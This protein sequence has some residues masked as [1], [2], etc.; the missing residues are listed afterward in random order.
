LHQAA[1]QLG[2]NLTNHLTFEFLTRLKLYFSTFYAGEEIDRRL[3]YD[4]LTYDLVM[5]VIK[6][7]DRW[8]PLFPLVQ[9][10]PQVPRVWTQRERDLIAEVRGWLQLQ[11]DEEWTSSFLSQSSAARRSRLSC[12][13]QVHYNILVRLEECNQWIND[14]ASKF[15]LFS[16]APIRSLTIAHLHVTFPNIA[17]ELARRYQ[18][19]FIPDFLAEVNEDGFE[20]DNDFWGHVLNFEPV[21][22]NLNRWAFQ[23]LCTD[24]YAVSLVF[25]PHGAAE[26][27][28][29]FMEG[30]PAQAQAPGQAPVIAEPAV[31]PAQLL[32]EAPQAEVQVWPPQ[33]GRQRYNRRVVP[34]EERLAALFD[35]KT[36]VFDRVLESL[37]TYWR[38]VARLW[39]RPVDFR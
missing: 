23:S 8:D 13:L 34:L 37:P 31:R 2:T 16:M 24:G 6:G 19:P 28:A 35:F 22:V 9:G 36:A 4:R 21:K 17:Q 7:I 15:T 29:P 5:G 11:E 25:A 3:T 18:A 33:D 39:P 1:A 32:G 30:P 10:Q 20:A 38:E 26:A 12:M 27:R 14:E